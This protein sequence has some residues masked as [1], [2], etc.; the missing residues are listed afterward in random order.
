MIARVIATLGLVLA[1]AAL[2]GDDP[3]PFRIGVIGLV[4]G[5][6]HGVLH[7]AAGRD[8]L[9]IVGVYEPSRDLFD[10]FAADY[11]LG[12]E[13]YFDD[14]NAMLDT[15][16]PEGVSVMTSTRD[17]RMAVES[18]APRGVHLLVEKPLAATFADATAM[19]DLARAHGVHLLTNYETSWYASNHEAR[20]LTASGALGDINRIVVHDGH[21]GPIE[22]GCAPSFV[23]WLTDPVGNGGGGAIMDF[24]CYGANLSTWLL[25]GQRPDSVFAITQRLKPELYPKVDDQATILLTYPGVQAVVQASWAWPLDRKDL[26]VYCG[27]GYVLAD[28]WS[29]IE[30]STE[31]GP[32]EPIEA[33]P[34]PASRRDEWTY[35]AN[36]VRGRL[37]VDPL[38]S[39]ENNLV[40]MEI[41]D[42]AKESALSGCAV[43][44]DP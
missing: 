1:P 12:A 17:H 36:V 32:P 24:G 14:L 30:L 37:S 4:H 38:S 3:G 23:E 35:F 40:V 18:C 41:L 43:R 26:H 20:R 9:E 10:A 11:G 44:L 13:L 34:L 5:H 8:D 19:A 33:D 28:R 16:S 27:R 22:I 7:Q 39:L 6:V 2:A 21:P 29:A 25:N 42:A 15:T 31:F